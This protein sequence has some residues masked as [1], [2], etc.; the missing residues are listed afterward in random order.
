MCGA[1]MQQARIRTCLDAVCHG[2]EGCAR[3]LGAHQILLL[4]RE[5]DNSAEGDSA[6]SGIVL[7]TKTHFKFHH[8][9]CPYLKNKIVVYR[10]A[11]N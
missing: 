4:L 10:V 2:R 9:L 7:R 1:S 5:G 11:L 6:N 8:A 3:A